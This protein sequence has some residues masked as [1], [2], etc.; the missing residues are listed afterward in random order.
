MPDG[1]EYHNGLNRVANDGH[2]DP[3]GD[4]ITNAGEYAA[5]TD[6]Y[7]P[8]SVFSVINVTTELGGIRIDWQGGRD[9]W[10]F[11]EMRTDLLDSSGW[12][13]IYALPPPTPVTNAIIHFGNTDQGLY[14]RIRAER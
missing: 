10:Q 9:A 4:G 6:P 2:L 13:P 14:Y 5:D 7:D 12:A 1:W 11:L 8:E 3:D